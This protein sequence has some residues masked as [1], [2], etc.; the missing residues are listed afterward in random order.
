M[1]FGRSEQERLTDALLT[2]VLLDACT[3]D[4]GKTVGDRLKVTELVFLAAHSLFSEQTRAFNF[5]FYR[6]HYGPFT[7]ELYE[8]WEELGWMGFLELEPGTS[9]RLKLTEAGVKGAECYEQRLRQSGNHAI[10]Q[11]FKRI[12]DTYAQLSTGELLQRVYGM[13]IAPLGWRQPMAVR[14]IPKDAYLTGIL[15]EKE[16]KTSLNIDDDTVRDFFGESPAAQKSREKAGAAYE[17]IYAS[18]LAG[19]RAERAGL[20][21]TKV[22]LTEL[23]RKLE[24]GNG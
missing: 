22:S 16:A 8:T 9:G 5:S 3:S 2:L 21:G 17:E 24:G 4:D 19:V 11:T 20:P 13:E 15:E 6:Y 7:T 1:R 18:A 10:L 12:S 14:Q 23:R